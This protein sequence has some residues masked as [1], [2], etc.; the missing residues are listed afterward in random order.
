MVAARSSNGPNN[1]HLAA[2]APPVADTWRAMSHEHHERPPSAH[3]PI[4]RLDRPPGCSSRAD[5]A[6]PAPSTTPEAPNLGT[7]RY[8]RIGSRKGIPAASATV[9]IRASLETT[10]VSVAWSLSSRAAA[11]WMAS[12]ERRRTVVPT[13]FS[14]VVARV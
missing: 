14:T 4:R 2:H 9:R 5:P 10:T 13:D 8:A 6:S 7:P 12:R 11:K 3:W 1:I